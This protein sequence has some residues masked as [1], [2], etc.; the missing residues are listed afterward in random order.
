MKLFFAALTV[1]L[2]LAPLASA[3]VFVL[4]GGG[5]ITGD[6]LNRDQ[7]PRKQY[8]VQTTEGVKVTLDASQIKKVMR[9][10]PEEAEYDRIRPTYADTVE[11]QWKLGLWCRNHKLSAQR[12]VHLRRVIELDPNNVEA[13]RALG[14]SQVDNKWVTQEQ[15]MAAQGY[16]RHNGK[17]MSAQE[18]E[19]LEEKRKLE[20]VQSDWFQKVKRWRAWLGTNRD[21]QARDSIQS[22]TEPAA[23]RALAAGLF[24]E[25]EPESRELFAGVLAKIGTPEAAKALAEAAIY[26]SAVDVRLTC[27][28]HL[29][30]KKRPEVVSYFVAKLRDKDN[31]IVNRAGVALRRMKEP[32]AVGPLIDALITPHVYKIAKP[33]GDNSMSAGF[34][35]GGTG[36]SMGGGPKSIRKF[37][38]NEAVLGALVT[39]TG[40][41][42]NYDKQ[43]WKYW[44]STQK[45]PP[46]SLDARRD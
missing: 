34:G 5:Q 21:G 6:L 40:C 4:T 29:Q 39:I 43:A 12:A 9:S 19:L 36:M 26:D 17:W 44:L 33:G 23:V 10:R 24:D 45:K 22:I 30:D 20:S 38:Q 15:A 25:D 35:G 7:T 13:Y 31:A 3:E 32:S 27:L 18:K 8:V 28:D 46:N 42:F 2:T 14:Y 11:D 1:L 41:N 16:S 37:L